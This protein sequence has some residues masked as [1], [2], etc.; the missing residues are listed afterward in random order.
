MRHRQVGASPLKVSEIALGTGD[1]AG[2]MVYGS[3]PAAARDLVD[4]ALALGVDLFDCS[5]DYGK[6]LGEANLGRVLKE[7]GA[8]D[9][10]LIT[11]VEDHAGGLHDWAGR[12]QDQAKRG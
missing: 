6:G 12:G 11:K 7:I 2:G 1:T 10:K 9:A 3:S 8:P 5:P 4:K